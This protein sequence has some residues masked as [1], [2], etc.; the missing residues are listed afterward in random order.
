[1]EDTT[2]SP[3][4]YSITPVTAE[5]AV[6]VATV[7]LALYG[8]NFPVSYVYH[9]DQVLGEI[10]AGRLS[11]LLALAP[12]GEPIGYASV[13]KSSPNPALWEGGNL[14]VMP[15]H[16]RGNLAWDLF[17]YYLQPERMPGPPG[18]GMFVEAVCHHYF[19]QLGCAK[20]GFVDCAL[21]LDQMNGAD[22]VERAP[23]T[24]RVACLLQFHEQSEPSGICYLPEQ[25][26]DVLS[27]LLSQLQPRNTR[28]GKASLPLRGET[29]RSDSWFASAG[30]WRVSVKSA[31]ADW[32]TFLGELLDQAKQRSV[33]S[34]QVVLSTAL[35][36][37]TVLVEDMRQQGFF[38][39]GVFPRWFGNDG[40]MMQKVLDKKP[41]YDGI[42][43]YGD[44]AKSLL[45]FIRS[46]HETVSGQEPA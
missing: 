12:D 14:L 6:K 21:A 29:V 8:D 27:M 15:K 13:F 40:V 35:P 25:Y 33:T 7:F 46:D 3:P 42:K 9:P 2:I 37:M 10:N 18:D 19:T 28:K 43:L 45:E 41:D 26:F 11:A 31:G 23:E 4:P 5:N 16:S 34:L 39:G 38:L 17:Q 32:G 30:M 22:F 1:M 20:T 24:D 36:H 44:V